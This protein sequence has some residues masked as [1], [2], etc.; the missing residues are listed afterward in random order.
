M[1][2]VAFAVGGPGQDVFRCLIVV[3]GVVGDEVVDF[4]AGK[5]PNMMVL[6][7]G[8]QIDGGIGGFKRSCQEVLLVDLTVFDGG[9][10]KVVVG[11]K[12]AKPQCMLEN[13]LFAATRR[14][15]PCGAST[16]FS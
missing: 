13:G 6:E 14:H 2:I 4:L 15:F 5:V 16:D 10:V 11:I 1:G 9:Q 8:H 12:A 7:C 3:F